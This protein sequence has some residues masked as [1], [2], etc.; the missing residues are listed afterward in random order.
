MDVVEHM[1]SQYA[2]FDMEDPEHVLTG[3]NLQNSLLVYIIG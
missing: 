1:L 3:I 2:D